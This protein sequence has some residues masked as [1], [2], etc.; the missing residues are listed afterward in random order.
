M[1]CPSFNICGVSGT[2]PGCNEGGRYVTSKECE[3]SYDHS[4]G[5]FD[6]LLKSSFG[7]ESRQVKFL[8]LWNNFKKIIIT[9]NF[10]FEKF[11]VLLIYIIRLIKSTSHEEP[12]AVIFLH[13][14][15]RHIKEFGIEGQIPRISSPVKLEKRC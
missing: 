2:N 8:S 9:I 4:F 12:Q 5:R 15:W 7:L 11:L 10:I 13:G 1:R 3:H 6:I 14:I